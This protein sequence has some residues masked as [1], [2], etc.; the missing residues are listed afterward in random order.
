MAL[1]KLETPTYELVQPSTGKKI[2]FRPFLVKEHKI[3]LTM[4]EAEDDEVV[5]IVK[6][7]IDVCTF[8]QLNINS[9]PHFDIEYIFMMLRAKSIGESVDVIIT[10]A[11]CDEK[12]DASFNIEDIK[13]EN[14]QN[15]SNKVMIT[16][17]V[18]V[19]LSYPKFE[20][21]VKLYNKDNVSNVFELVRNSIIG[22]FEDDRYYDA[23]DQD[24]KEIE[25]FIYSLTKE[26]FEKIEE[27]FVTSPKVVQTVETDCI[28][29]NHHNVSRIEGLQNFFV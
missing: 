25:E 22:I 3:L 2:K 13:V 23:K 20:E 4:S 28:K 14:I 17:N 21:V 9:L 19:D 5:R 29:C 6:E 8:K 15:K 12:Y 24:P 11:N 7:L 10:C 27:F 1:P 16:K 26:Q 18:G